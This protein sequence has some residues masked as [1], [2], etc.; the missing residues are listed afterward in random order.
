VT[1]PF[2]LSFQGSHKERTSNCSH[3]HAVSR[4]S[5]SSPSLLR[6]LPESRAT[7]LPNRGILL[8][9]AFTTALVGRRRFLD[10]IKSTKVFVQTRS[11]DGGSTYQILFVYSMRVSQAPILSSLTPGPRRVRMWDKS[12]AHRWRYPISL[13]PFPIPLLS[14]CR[15]AAAASSRNPHHPFSKLIHPL[16]SQRNHKRSIPCPA[17]C[18]PSLPNSS[19]S[20]PRSLLARTRQAIVHLRRTALLVR[21]HCQRLDR[22]AVTTQRCRHLLCFETKLVVRFV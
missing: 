17:H 13:L 14:V 5:S 22:V 21:L 4:Q 1:E 2:G 19:P 7:V 8:K 18:R 3:Y 16:P 11:R 15:N 10:K 6:H 9:V 12:A 20:H